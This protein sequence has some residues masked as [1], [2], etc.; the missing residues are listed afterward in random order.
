M[1]HIAAATIA[2]F[3]LALATGC[4]PLPGELD[5]PWAEPGDETSTEE[6]LRSSSDEPKPI[7]GGGFSSS[8]VNVKRTPDAGINKGF[9]GS[10]INVDVD[11]DSRKGDD[12]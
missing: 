8:T 1:F 12:E 7:L 2:A 9:T 10:I 4:A 5:D 6:A 3:L 11:D